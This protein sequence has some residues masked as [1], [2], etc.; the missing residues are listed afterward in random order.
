MKATVASYQ[1]AAWC[2]RI[3]CKNGGPV[4]RLTSYPVNLTMSNATVYLTDSGYDITSYVADDGMAPSALD[5][6]GI[7]QIGG[8]TRE[9]VA[10]GIFDGARVNIF[11]CNVSS[12][13]E[14]YDPIM[15]GFFGKATVVDERY[16]IEAMSLVDAFNE[17]IGQTYS[18]LC[19][20][21]FGDARCKKAL[22]GA[23]I[24]VTGTLTSV[25]S[26]SS[27]G[28]SARAEAADYFG[29]GTFRFTS[30]ANAN[31]PALEVKSFSAGAI[32]THETFYYLPAIGDAYEM[33]AGCRK[34][35]VDCRDKW[36]N[37]VNALAFWDM[38]VSG[39]YISR[40]EN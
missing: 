17:V 36:N 10:V 3:T 18:P 34:R 32:V 13:V 16:R 12:P 26:G 9:Q 29:A 5:L 28:D 11:K 38:P 33:V 1:N 7:M 19:G 21:T 35:R 23:P 8:V 20:H 15:A 24:T 14:D 25:T 39:V 30:G 6:E 2:V 40:G 37:V 4:I 22:A 27:F 31:L